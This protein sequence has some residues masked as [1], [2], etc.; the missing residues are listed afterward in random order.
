[1]AGRERLLCAGMVVLSGSLLMGTVPGG[2]RAAQ[3]QSAG[4]NDARIVAEAQKQLENKRFVNVTSAVHDGNVTLGGTVEVYADK[5]DADWR[6]HH[7]KQ[8]KG[9]DN[10][11][12]IAGPAVDDST[13]RNKLSQALAY[14]RVGYGTTAFNAVAIHVQNGVVTLGGT[15]YGPADKDSAIS[16]V[17]HTPGVKDIVDNLEV[18]PV[19]P[20]DD[21]LRIELARV[22]YGTPQLQKYALNP[23]LP[24]RITVVNGNVTLS[25]VVDNKMD[26]DVAGL[27]ANGVPGVF[28]VVND[29]QVAGPQSPK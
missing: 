2:V 29:L 11:I 20:M 7:V 15:V 9:V 10:E 21:R 1:M 13:L 23:A 3:A 18:A 24:I 16:L 12:A 4:G 6:V 28:K 5:E 14:D 25:G 27:R 8:V 22:I 26:H 19:S 17:G